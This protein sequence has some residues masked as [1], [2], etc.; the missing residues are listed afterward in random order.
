MHLL[1]GIILAGLALSLIMAAAWKVQRLTGNSGWIDA[2]WTLGTGAVAC[3]LALLPLQGQGEPGWRQL[4][5]AAFIACWSLR[6][7]WH[8]VER[9][10][11]TDDDPRYRAMLNAWG[12]RGPLRLLWFLQAQAAVALVLVAAVMLAAHQPDLRFRW[13]DGLAIAVFL[14][15]L[16][17]EALADAQLRRF[18]QTSRDREAL[19]DVGL[20]SWSRH[21]NYFGEW[22]CW[23]A[24]PLFSI[25]TAFP[26]GW[27]ALLAPI[28]MYW[29]L[30][31]ASGIPP[32]E[33]HMKRSRPKAFAAYK[34]RTNAFFPGPPRKFLG[35]I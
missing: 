17:C 26:A 31:Y 16:G 15:G 30:V 27:L 20:W 11:K 6:L 14:A 5:A 8:I 7:S 24:W 9:T 12:P 34:R 2:I 35:R 19:C 3:V 1:A 23:C 25:G 28:F 21:P 33:A 29:T 4:I 32:L 22:L 18:K 13:Q 10:R